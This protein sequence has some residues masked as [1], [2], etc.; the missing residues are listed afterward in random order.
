MSQRVQ[1]KVA[2]RHMEDRRA[3]R[4][5][6][7][8]VLGVKGGGSPYGSTTYKT[9]RLC[10]FE[11]AL[12]K[13]VGLVPDREHEA[14]AIGL[15][16]HAAL[17]AY[18]RVIMEHQQALGEPPRGARAREEYCWGAASRAENAAL[19]VVDLFAKEPGYRQTHH[20]AERVVSGYLER[21][22]R[23]DQ[24]R[25]LAVE[26]TLIYEERVEE[27]VRLMQ[28]ATRP[29]P[30]EGVHVYTG[31]EL[32]EI[33]VDT[34]AYSTRLDVVVQDIR[35]GRG[36]VWDLEH[37]TARLINE[38]LVHG[39]QMDMQILGQVWLVLRCL[40]LDA[41]PGPFMGALVNIA[42]KAKTP[43]FERVEVCPS[44]AHLHAFED[45]TRRW[46]VMNELFGWAGHPKAL[47]CCAGA[48][49]GYSRCDFYDACQRH[50]EKTIA[51]FMREPAP[52]G[53][54]KRGEP[55]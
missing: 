22:R 35:P 27:P 30:I 43:R 8:V 34:F 42:T 50:P 52:E 24:W 16:F 29:S 49:R 17:E 12:G 38:H 39:Y 4:R 3:P 13:I 47:G 33:C 32:D 37:K 26:E 6:V 23:E 11:H 1:F 44:D 18:Y 46:S 41:L 5:P 54:T 2:A 21:Y 51:D 53:Y 15:I 14:L 55:V 9:R 45:S 28:L 31:D 19:D 40:D 36:G 48:L 20:D 10:P 25:V 7:D